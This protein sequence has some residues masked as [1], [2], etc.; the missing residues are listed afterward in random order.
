MVTKLRRGDHEG[1]AIALKAHLETT[2]S[3]IREQIED[4]GVDSGSNVA[5]LI[6]V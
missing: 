6:T 5:R 3:L 2:V 1:A 4:V